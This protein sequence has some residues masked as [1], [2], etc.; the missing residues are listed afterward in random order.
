MAVLQMQRISICA[1]KK[2][3]KAILE[4]LQSLGVLEID[5]AEL[6]PELETMDTMN[7]RLIFEKNASLCDQAIEIL[8]EFSKEKTSM[9]ASLAGKPLIG[10]TQEEEAIA[11]QEEILKTA[12]EILEYR[13]KLTENSAA[14]IKIEQQE[15]ALT[16]WLALDIPMNFA[17]TA[18]SAILIGSIDGNVTL[19]QVYSQLAVDAPQ[20]EAFDIQAV[21]SEAGKLCLAAVCLK[22]QAQELEEALR[23]QGFARPAQLVSGISAQELQNLQD[24]VARIHEE[25][26][27]TEEKIRSLHNNKDKLQLIS[28]YFR[29]RAQ[30][31]EV[32]GQLRQ[33]ASTF[34][35]TGY[36]PKKQVPSIEKRLTEKYDIVFEAEDAEGEGVPVVLKNGKFGAAGE[37]VLAAFGLPGKGE[38][39]PSTIMTA[40][41]VFLFGLMLSDAAYGLIVFAVCLG[42]LLKFPRM[43]SGMQKSIRLFM[44]CGLSTLFWGVMFGGYFGDFVDVF[45]RVYLH[46]PVTIKP[47]WFAPL[48]EPMRLL[49]FSMLF[50]LIHMFLGMG[51]KGYMLIRDKKYLDFFCDVVLWFM[52]LM[53]LILI[54]IPSSMFRSISQMD[55]NLPAVVIQIGKWMAI[56]GAVGILLMSGR[57]KKNPFLRLA[58]GAYDLY[59]ITGWVSDILSYSRLLALGLAT[60]VIASVMNQM[61][62]MLGD[63]IFGWIVFILVFVIGHTFNLLINLLGA[64]VHTCRLQYV[65]FFGKFFEGG[66]KEFHPFRENTKYVDIKED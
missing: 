59:N 22:E 40:C 17:G 61:G 20:L 10:R 7:A 48:N 35:V 31:Y 60:G 8:D 56:I 65:E 43:E 25:S 26:G 51:L 24:Q 66:G 3:R 53:G 63:S 19:E 32:L 44:Y 6:D 57:D 28:D 5:A 2:N 34:F 54:F 64:Y 38:I 45:S 41:Y 29:I 23:M 50:G 21:S 15:A 47:V 1:M 9:L 42:V 14:V 4:E 52:L 18:A 16:P 36:L 33:S 13:K 37:G 39:D 62:S 12:R 55:L 49:V 30:K 27:E 11:S 58:L 46:R